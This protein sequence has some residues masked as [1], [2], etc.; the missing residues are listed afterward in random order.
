MPTQSLSHFKYLTLDIMISLQVTVKF[1]LSPIE[2]AIHKQ[3]IKKVYLRNEVFSSS[4]YPYVQF[5]FFASI[6]NV[7]KLFKL[8]TPFLHP[9]MWNSFYD[10]VATIAYLVSSLNNRKLRPRVTGWI[11][12]NN[13]RNRG[14]PKK[15]WED[16][17]P[18]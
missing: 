1:L 15:R 9:L 17:I 12:R 8:H 3:T 2:S 18:T 4:F 10:T 6:F 5:S 14:R 13:R 16:I 7:I 11:P